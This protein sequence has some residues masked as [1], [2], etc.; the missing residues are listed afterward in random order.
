[1]KIYLSEC[2]GCLDMPSFGLKGIG[3]RPSATMDTKL[4]ET[5]ARYQAAHF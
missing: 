5:Q 1:M 3:G 4:A 2:S